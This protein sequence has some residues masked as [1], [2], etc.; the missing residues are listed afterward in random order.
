[1]TN[2]QS[3][4]HFFLRSLVFS[5]SISCFVH[6]ILQPLSRSGPNRWTN[7]RKI[8]KLNLLSSVPRTS[9]CFLFFEFFKRKLGLCDRPFVAGT[10]GGFLTFLVVALPSF[11]RNFKARMKSQLKV[12]WTPSLLKGLTYG[13]FHGIYFGIFESFQ[14]TNETKNFILACCS[15]ISAGLFTLPLENFLKVFPEKFI[16]GK[17]KLFPI[18]VETISE[19][20][21]KY[22]FRGEGLGLRAT[23]AV[24][25]LYFYESAMKV[26]SHEKLELEGELITE[27]DRP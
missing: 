17:Q 15:T 3:E 27:L 14:S 8:N 13:Q 24:L 12:A 16:P 4:D 22:F 1:M 21:W 11:R 9:M 5:T 19:K 10:L 25:V 23:A 2:N 18:L 20:G 26:A 7:F 6:T